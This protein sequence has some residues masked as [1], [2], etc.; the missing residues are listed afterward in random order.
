MLDMLEESERS[1]GHAMI[2]LS[3]VWLDK[4]HVLENLEKLFQGYENYA[5]PVVFVM[6]GNFSEKPIVGDFP[7]LVKLFEQLAK[8]IAK[9]PSIR[10]DS[11]FVF[12]PGLF[13]FSNFR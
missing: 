8:L 10:S 1:P 9:Y 5:T 13:R 4:A 12:I 6:M 2:F 7:K 11:H 3:D